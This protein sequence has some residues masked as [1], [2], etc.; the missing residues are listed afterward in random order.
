MMRSTWT[1]EVPIEDHNTLNLQRQPT[2]GRTARLKNRISQSCSALLK[3]VLLV[4]PSQLYAMMKI[5]LSSSLAG[6]GSV[7]E[8]R[9]KD[10]S[11]A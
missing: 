2:L 7:L 8:A 9:L 4:F 5:V 10:C 1:I 3:Y 11:A 6:D